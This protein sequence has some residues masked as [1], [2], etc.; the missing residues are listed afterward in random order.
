MC[1]PVVQLMELLLT[2]KALCLFPAGAGQLTLL[3]KLKV[4]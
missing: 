1:P 2:K 3:W 4:A